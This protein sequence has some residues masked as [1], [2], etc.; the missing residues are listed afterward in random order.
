MC[1]ECEAQL[2]SF[3]AYCQ[4]LSMEGKECAECEY[5]MHYYLT[6]VKNLAPSVMQSV[7]A[8]HVDEQCWQ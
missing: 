2:E 8:P 3:M 4:T 7:P 6:M 1:S 5:A